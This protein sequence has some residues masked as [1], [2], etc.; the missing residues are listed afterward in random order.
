M[1]NPLTRSAMLAINATRLAHIPDPLDWLEQQAKTLLNVEN[2]AVI[3]HDLD[4]GQD[5]YHVALKLAKPVRLNTIA[6][7]FGQEP[8]VVEMWKGNTDNMWSYMTHQ[9]TRAKAE[10]A[11]YLP[12]LN[13][14]K[15]SRWDSPE[16]QA[17]G[18][19]KIIPKK[20]SEIEQLAEQIIQGIVTKRDLLQPEM[21]QTYWKHMNLL[22][23]AL[24]VRNMSLVVAPPNCQTY[25]IQG[26]SGTGKTSYAR[27]L[28]DQ[29]YPND[30]AM[31]SAGNDPLQDYLGEKC[32]IIDEFRPQD[33]PLP[34]LLALLDPYHRTRTHKSRYYNKGLATELILITSTIT[35]D[36]VV[37]YYTDY[38]K[39]DPKQITRR[40][41]KIID[42]DE[43][44]G[45]TAA[46]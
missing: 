40:I 33:Y 26:A 8:N 45:S 11:D 6:K 4:Q 3:I 41:A 9:T 34:D 5:H 24:K 19:H 21:V 13:D 35:L 22:D 1:A 12:Y 29:K 36:D 16:T 2:Y 44:L 43:M 25:Y 15:K 7:Q 20:N 23:R 37:R 14:P 39:E 30:N 17:K 10:K 27:A 42:L 31:A 32:L 46:Q 18:A 38:T 28:A